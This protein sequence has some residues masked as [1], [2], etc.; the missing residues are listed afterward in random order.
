MAELRR[1][2]KLTLNSLPSRIRSGAAGVMKKPQIIMA[3]TTSMALERIKASQGA[4]GKTS[5][6]QKRSVADML[7]QL[8]EIA[9]GMLEE[10][11]LA[12]EPLNKRLAMAKDVAK[13]LPLLDRAERRSKSYHRNKAVEDMTDGELTKAYRALKA[14]KS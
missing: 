5:R 2:A 1:V 9:G 12:D 4:Q 3:P 8:Y 13:L 6:G 11:N 7:S 14:G 10:L